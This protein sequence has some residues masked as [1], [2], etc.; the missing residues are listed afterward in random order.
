MRPDSRGAESPDA[1]L[2]WTPVT[3]RGG[4]GQTVDATGTARRVLLL[5]LAVVAV[6]AACAPKNRSHARDT[7]VPMSRGIENQDRMLIGDA[8]ARQPADPSRRWIIVDPVSTQASLPGS[9]SNYTE[10]LRGAVIAELLT[11]P[12]IRV[13]PA[14]QV[15]QLGDAGCLY[16]RVSIQQFRN[17]ISDDE[18][19]NQN[20]AGRSRERREMEQSRALVEVRN[21]ARG[22]YEVCEVVHVTETVHRD[23]ESGMFGRSKKARDRRRETDMEVLTQLGGEIVQELDKRGLLST[24][25]HQHVDSVE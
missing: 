22:P 13:A 25:A 23:A 6:L 3:P 4:G 24:T 7:S 12:M 21:G 16:V 1:I 8:E 10:A 17:V 5:S 9:A 19:R 15:E 18:A 2:E 14:N 20:I 11:R